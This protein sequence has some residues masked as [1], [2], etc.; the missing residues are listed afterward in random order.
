LKAGR[1]ADAERSFERAVSMDGQNIDA[2]V[3]LAQTQASLG[4]GAQAVESY[5][6][7]ALL[8]PGS[9]ELQS[10]LGGAYESTGDWQSAEA[11]YRRALGLRADFGPAANNLAYLMLEHGGDLNVATSLAQTARRNMPGLPN[12]ADTLG[13]AYYRGG[14]FRSAAPMFEEAV[15]RE[16]G[17]ATYHYHLGLAYQKLNDAGRAKVELQKAIN[18]NPKSAVA[19]EARRA[20]SQ[21]G[22]G[23]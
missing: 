18:V 5:R 7:A 23:S 13:W 16:P 10:A 8:A 17:N 1:A 15:K 9:A 2:V 20:E 12:P 21:A 22:G 3:A 14:L 19:E 6:K 11:S 4:Q